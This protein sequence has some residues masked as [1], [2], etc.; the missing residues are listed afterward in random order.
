MPY[1]PNRYAELL[2]ERMKKHH[3][4]VF[5]VNTGWTGGPYG[6][7]Q[8][9]DIGITRS[10]IHAAMDGLLDKVDYVTDPLFHLDIPKSC[11]GVPAKMLNPADTWKDKAEFKK[12]ALKL[13]GEFSDH[14]D[15]AYANKKIDKKVR[16][17]CPGK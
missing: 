9:M 10:I 5:L 1:L 8:R 16:A 6:V 3:S 15:R 11:P 13:A 2:G 7:G 4:K 12:R 14:F 17:Q